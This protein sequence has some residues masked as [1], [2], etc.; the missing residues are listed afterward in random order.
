[1]KNDMKK[2]TILHLITAAKNASPFDVNM[3]FDAGFENIV[4][5]TNITLNEVT[6]L[7]QDAIFSRSASGQKSEAIFIGGRDI[8]LTMDMLEAAKKALFHHLKFQC[9]QI[10]Q[11]L[12]LRVQQWWPRLNITLNGILIP[13]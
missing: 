5:Y 4:P 1:M 12:S 8:D 9:L 2:V 3:A 10:L 7:T 6:G 13:I 11:V